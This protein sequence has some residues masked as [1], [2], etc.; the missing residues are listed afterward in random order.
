MLFRSAQGKLSHDSVG[1]MLSGSSSGPALIIAAG[2]FE[3]FV[4]SHPTARLVGIR[5]VLHPIVAQWV[6]EY[7]QIYDTHWEASCGR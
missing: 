7:L 6:L 4:V 5:T 3:L 2:L 1:A